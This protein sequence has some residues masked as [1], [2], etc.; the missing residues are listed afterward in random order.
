M[1]K[2]KLQKIVKTPLDRAINSREHGI[3]RM[4]R[5]RREI[6]KRAEKE[7]AVIDKHIAEKRILL[8]ALKR[9]AIQQ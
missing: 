7:C 9:G 2:I 8:D 4:E 1:A 5:N 3:A 6:M